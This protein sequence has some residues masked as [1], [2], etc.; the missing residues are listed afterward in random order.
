[1]NSKAYLALVVLAFIGMIATFI[2]FISALA[3]DSFYSSDATVASI[4]ITIFGF[5]GLFLLFVLLMVYGLVKYADPRGR[6][7]H[8]EPTKKCISCGQELAMTDLSCHRCFVLQP[9]GG[10]S[11]GLFKRRR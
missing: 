2:F 8:S 1:M 3:S 9:P 4:L 11:P 6:S 10:S 5:I 7:Y